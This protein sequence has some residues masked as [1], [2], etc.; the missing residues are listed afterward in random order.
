MCYD[1]TKK[2]LLFGQKSQ[3]KCVLIEVLLN[4]SMNTIYNNK[5]LK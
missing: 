1:I 5:Y 3:R 4:G 2:R